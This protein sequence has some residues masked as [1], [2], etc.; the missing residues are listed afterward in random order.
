MICVVMACVEKCV[1]AHVPV[2]HVFTKPDA[3][4]GQS[5]HG[6]TGPRPKLKRNFYISINPDGLKLKKY[7]FC[8]QKK[9]IRTEII[10]NT[11]LG[12]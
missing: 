2:F 10:N 7:A 11:I 3:N 9:I 8:D 1:L 5:S 6:L 4:R 12:Y